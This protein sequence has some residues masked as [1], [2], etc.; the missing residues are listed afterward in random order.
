MRPREILPGDNPRAALA[1]L[2]KMMALGQKQ[3]A[4]EFARRARR[5]EEAARPEAVAEIADEGEL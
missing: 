3:L 1:S 2:E 5:A 4:A